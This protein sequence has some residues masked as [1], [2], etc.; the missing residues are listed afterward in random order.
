MT[1]KM[2][3]VV[4]IPARSRVVDGGGTGVENVKISRWP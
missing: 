3:F 2:V 1:K 4:Q